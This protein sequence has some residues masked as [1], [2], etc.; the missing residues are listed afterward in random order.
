MTIDTHAH[1]YLCKRPIE[2]IVETAKAAGLS[3]ILCVALDHETG[4]ECLKL[5]QQFPIFVPTIGI[6][7]CERKSFS[8]IEKIEDAIKTYPFKAIGEIGLD[9]HWDASYADEQK[10]VLKSQLEMARKANLPVIIHSRNSD[11]DMVNFMK[12]YVDIKRVFH[13]FSSDWEVAQSLL[14]PLTKFSFTGMIT[15]AKKGKTIEVI[16]N[17]SLDQLMIETDC[18]YLTPIQYKGEENQP[19]YVVEVAK[20]IAEIKEISYEKVIEVTTRNAIE[21]FNLK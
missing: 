15:S 2:E 13:C 11:S 14:S 5:S 1:P 3:N 7:P 9:Y 17:L 10:V 4:M 8:Q 6:H 20:K 18:P 19:A 16:R 12:N 21:F